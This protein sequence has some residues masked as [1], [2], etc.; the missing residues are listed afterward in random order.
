MVRLL[1]E[2][3][4]I[5]VDY[6]MVRRIISNLKNCNKKLE[7]KHVNAGSS[8]ITVSKKWDVGLDD[9]RIFLQRRPENRTAVNKIHLLN[10]NITIV[11]PEVSEMLT[12]CRYFLLFLCFVVLSGNESYCCFD[13]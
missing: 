6:W 1:S 12:L 2:G 5:E 4:D 7:Q 3:N 10:G 13:A 8:R 9:D 11:Y